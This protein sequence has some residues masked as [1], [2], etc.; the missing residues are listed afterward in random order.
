MN[1][2]N[3]YNY[4]NNVYQ[5]NKLNNNNN[6]KITFILTVKSGKIVTSFQDGNISILE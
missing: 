6:K 2:N 3:N 1:Y 4:Y 5:E